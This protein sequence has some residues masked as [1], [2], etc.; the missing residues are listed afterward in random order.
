MISIIIPVLN[1]EGGVREIID[2]LYSCD[3][4]ADQEIIFVDGGSTDRTK[5][6]INEKGLEVYLSPERGRAGQ[7]NFGAK[8]AKGST[9]FFLHS[10]SKPPGNFIKLINEAVQN[11]FSSGCF[12]LLFDS[13]HPL[14]KFYS[15]FT[16]YDIDY[17]RFGDQG[18]FITTELFNNVNGYDEHHLVME[19]QHM[20]RRV[21]RCSSFKIINA[22]IVTSARKYHKNGVIRLQFIFMVI[23][24]LYY[25]GVSQEGLVEYYKSKLR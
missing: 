19:D 4:I 2:H 6:R 12:R 17:F 23:V 7:M 20:V 21:K 14:L 16:K 8:K 11:N 1:E 9:L 5:E 18:L 13:K 24:F 15:W 25:F 10:D 3:N 22:D